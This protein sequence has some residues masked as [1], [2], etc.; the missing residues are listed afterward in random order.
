MGE[1]LRVLVTDDEEGIRLGVARVLEKYVASFPD[2]DAEIRYDVES[3]AS[4]EDAVARLHDAPPDV[5]LLDLKLPGIGGLDVLREARALDSA[6]ADHHDH[7]LRLGDHR[8]RGHPGRDLR[9]SAQA[10]HAR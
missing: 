10:L 2:I 9:L 4:G 3:A 7:R 6:G 1:R 5:L 8:G